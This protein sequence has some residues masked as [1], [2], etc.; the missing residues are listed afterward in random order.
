MIEIVYDRMRLRLTADGHAGFAEAGQDIVCAAVSTLAC[1]LAENV[2]D[3]QE[4]GMLQEEPDI[5]LADGCA[6]VRARPKRAWRKTM[7]TIF[8]A[9][10]IGFAMA[11]EQYPD[12]VK[13]R[14]ELGT[15]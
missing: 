2:L 10:C 12:R 1:V 15:D 8:D 6:R 13:M 9:I 14:A 5:Y 11:A 4:H 3:A 7:R